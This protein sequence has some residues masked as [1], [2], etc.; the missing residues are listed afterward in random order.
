MIFTSPLS[1][2][3]SKQSPQTSSS[4]ATEEQASPYFTHGLHVLSWLNGIT[5]CS[6]IVHM[7]LVSISSLLIDLMQLV[8]YSVTCKVASLTA[9]ALRGHIACTTG[10]SQGIISARPLLLLNHIPK[11]RRKP[12][13]GFS[14]LVS[15]DKRLPHRFFGAEYRSSLLSPM[16]SISGLSL[17]ELEPHIKQPKVHLPDNVQVQVSLHSRPCSFI[18]NPEWT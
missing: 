7:P 2:L 14:T 17:K 15:V 1:R 11:I 3:T 4:L 8:Q 5:P 13:N 18:M 9:G 16:L 6:F 12:R 10:H